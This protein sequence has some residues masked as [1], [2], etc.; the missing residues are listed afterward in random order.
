VD[1]PETVMPEKSR[2]WLCV[3]CELVSADDNTDPEAMSTT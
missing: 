1:C 2:N 3:V